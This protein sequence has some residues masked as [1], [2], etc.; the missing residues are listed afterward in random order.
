MCWQSLNQ[1]VDGLLIKGGSRVSIDSPDAN[2]D[3]DIDSA[4]A[5]SMC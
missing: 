1:D 2:I 5:F 4:D 3:A